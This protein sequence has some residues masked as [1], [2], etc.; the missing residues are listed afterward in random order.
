MFPILM[1]SLCLVAGWVNE[2]LKIDVHTE[3]PVEEV[4]I[5]LGNSPR[6]HFPNIAIKLYLFKVS[7]KVYQMLPLCPWNVLGKCQ[8]T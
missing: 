5:G 4:D 6:I 1:H 7:Q 8:C 2:D 3:L